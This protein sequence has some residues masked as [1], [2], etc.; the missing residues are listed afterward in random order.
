MVLELGGSNY[1]TVDFWKGK[2][3]S[4]HGPYETATQN[5]ILTHKFLSN[6]LSIVLELQQG[7]CS[8]KEY[9]EEFYRL[10]ARTRLVEDESQQVA[11]YIGVYM[12]ESR[13]NYK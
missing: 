6:P 7:S 3:Q 12:R 2:I 4:H 5:H 11:R 9:M 13:K 1:N 8:I 10:G